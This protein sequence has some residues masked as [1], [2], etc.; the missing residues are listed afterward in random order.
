MLGKSSKHFELSVSI[1]QWYLYFYNPQKYT[2]TEKL[3]L[4]I[5]INNFFKSLYCARIEK[6]LHIVSSEFDLLSPL[7][8][9]W[10]GTLSQ[11]VLIVCP[12]SFSSG[13]T[14]S[15]YLLHW[16][17]TNI[18]TYQWN[19]S[20]NDIRIRIFRGHVQKSKESFF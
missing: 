2:F 3:N 10:K 5:A 12:F 18:I 9:P 15:M 20:H 14:L 7:L 19:N 13:W 11:T 16:K 8:K 1:Q 4:V 17:H 6:P